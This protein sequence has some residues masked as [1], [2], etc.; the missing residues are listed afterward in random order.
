[1]S[2]AEFEDRYCALCGSQRCGGV[3]DADFR[4]GC[5]YYIDEL[6]SEFGDVPMNPATECIEE[7]WR[8]FPAGTHREDIW[9]WFE[10]TFNVSVHDLMYRE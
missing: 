10:N 2:K 9:H 6:W 8:D 4:N 1:M 7:S 5:R 3:D